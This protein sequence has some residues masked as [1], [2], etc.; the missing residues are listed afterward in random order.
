MYLQLKSLEGT[1]DA[2]ALAQIESEGMRT[3][4]DLD[5]ARRPLHLAGVRHMMCR[6][7]LTFPPQ[8]SDIDDPRRNK[9]VRLLRKMCDR[10]GLLP[11]SHMLSEGLY[12]TSEYPLFRGGYADVWCGK[13]DDHPV[14]IKALRIYATED[15]AKVK[16]VG[17]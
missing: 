14:A 6:N 9:A 7:R 2:T 16:K 11:T 1:L 12:K 15:M 17:E 8:L 3:I 10:L 13:L 5:H 4:D